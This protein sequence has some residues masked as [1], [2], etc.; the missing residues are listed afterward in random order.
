MPRAKLKYEI[1]AEP[2]GKLASRTLAMPTDT[3]P[4]GHIFGG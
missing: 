4:M 3:N 1:H 2:K